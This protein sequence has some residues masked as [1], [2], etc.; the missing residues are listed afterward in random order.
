MSGCDLLECTL[1][2]LA[3]LVPFFA[4]KL[5]EVIKRLSRKQFHKDVD[6]IPSR[7][8]HLII[9]LCTFVI[10]EAWRACAAQISQSVQAVYL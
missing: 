5:P 3:N 4:R 10:N 6:N 2:G 7:Q 9:L 8:P 1:E